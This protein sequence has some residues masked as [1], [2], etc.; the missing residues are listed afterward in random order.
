MVG[1]PRWQLTETVRSGQDGQDLR[2][3]LQRTWLLPKRMVHYLR[4]RQNVMVNGRYQPMNY[5]VAAGDVVRMAF[6][7]DE[8]RTPEA[9]HYLPTPQPHLTVLYENSDL[10]VVSKPRGQKTHPNED[11]ETGTLMNDAAGYLGGQAFMVH[12]IDKQRSGEV[13]IAK[14][15]VVVPILDRLMA[16]GMIHRQYLAVVDACLQG[17]GQWRWPICDDPT[18]PWRRKVAGEGANQR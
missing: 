11:D 16:A 13:I 1:K 6:Q 14:N 3:L 10:L 7:G 15:P 18:D 12:R 2:S 4:I 5:Q 9:N 8:F 17:Q